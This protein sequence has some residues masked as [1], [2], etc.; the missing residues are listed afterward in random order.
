MSEGLPA[1]SEHDLS[2]DE[3]KRLAEA[4]VELQ[5]AVASEERYL[6]ELG[7]SQAVPVVAAEV[8][9]EAQERVEAAEERLWRV[10]DE[11]LGWARPP[12]APRASLIGDWFSDEDADYDLLTDPARP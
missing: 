2:S 12:W 4:L 6:A 11:L 8:L 10:R 7:S 9:R 1:R 5:A 3:R